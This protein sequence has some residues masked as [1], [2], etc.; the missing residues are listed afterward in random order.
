ML[1]VEYI[2]EGMTIQGIRGNRHCFMLMATAYL[3]LL[4]GFSLPYLY[5]HTIHTISAMQSGKRDYPYS[6]CRCFQEQP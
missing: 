6:T 4:P 1:T 5:V 3:P 2:S